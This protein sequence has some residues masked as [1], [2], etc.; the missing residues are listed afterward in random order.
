VDWKSIEGYLE[1]LSKEKFITIKQLDKFAISITS[2][3][4]AKVKA[5]NNNFVRE[6]FSL[7]DPRKEQPTK[8][9]EEL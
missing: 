5:L 3:G 1:A 6:T 8:R 2:S 4:I 9:E 7:P